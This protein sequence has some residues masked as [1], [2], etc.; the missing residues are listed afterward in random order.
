MINAMSLAALRRNFALPLGILLILTFQGLF[1]TTPVLLGFASS[2]QQTTHSRSCLCKNCSGLNNRKKCCC[3]KADS[4][5]D[6][7]V[8]KA[9]C[10]TPQDILQVTEQ[11]PRAT[12]ASLTISIALPSLP[13]DSTLSALRFDGSGRMPEPTLQPP[14]S[15]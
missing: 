2:L 5:A 4:R 13:H 12:C 3:I 7:K 9:V 14:R 11:S 15:L 8:F 1:D 6:C 10:D